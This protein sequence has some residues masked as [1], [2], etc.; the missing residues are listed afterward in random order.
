MS[1][2]CLVHREALT[3]CISD[4]V[5]RLH[6]NVDGAT[7]V[8]PI[9]DAYTVIVLLCDVGVNI[10]GRTSMVWAIYTSLMALGKRPV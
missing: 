8:D 10:D 9:F 2:A 4:G 6:V 1:G 5:G 7:F 3:N